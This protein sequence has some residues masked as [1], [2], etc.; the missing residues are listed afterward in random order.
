MRLNRHRLSGMI[1]KR[2]RELK[3][4]MNENGMRNVFQRG[5]CKIIGS[6]GTSMAI[7]ISALA[8]AP[9]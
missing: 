9:P 4:M 3:N 1:R 5:N 2:M 8:S 6:K 7:A